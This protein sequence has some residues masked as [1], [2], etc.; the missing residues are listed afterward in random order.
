MMS[1]NEQVEVKLKPCPNPWCVRGGTLGPAL[2]W[3]GPK[4]AFVECGSCGLRGPMF[5]PIVLNDD[6]EQVGTRDAEAEAIAAWNQRP[7]G[8]ADERVARAEGWRIG[9]SD[10]RR[11]AVE[12]SNYGH[13]EGNKRAFKIVADIEYRMGVDAPSTQGDVK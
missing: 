6:G 4:E 7:S 13:V 8:I 11:I 1:D 9:M 3:Q 5:S 10:A 12:N 2:C